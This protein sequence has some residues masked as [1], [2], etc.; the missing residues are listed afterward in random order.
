[1]LNNLTKLTI[2]QLVALFLWTPFVKAYDKVHELTISQLETFQIS[3]NKVTLNNFNLSEDDAFM[4][5]GTCKVVVTFSVVNR[6]DV[7]KHFTAMFVGFE[8]DSIAWSVDAEP[9]FASVSENKTEEC[10]GSAY[11][12][13]GTL[14]KTTK[15]WLRVV[16]DF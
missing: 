13:P 6:N 7:S 11:V 4:A 3:Q 8:N 9:S 14:S 1:M 5:K 12:P 10:R 16:G 15:I 2:I